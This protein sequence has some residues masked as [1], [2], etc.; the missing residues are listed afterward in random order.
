MLGNLTGK[1]ILLIIVAVIVVL[2]A[3][4]WFMDD[5]RSP[6]KKVKN[7]QN[8][9][10]TQ[11]KQMSALSQPADPT[12]GSPSENTPY[13][14]YNFYSPNCGHSVAFMPAWQQ[15]EKRIANNDTIS[16]KAIDATQPENSD[17]LFYYNIKG[18][19]TIILKT[20]QKYLEYSGD[21]T[22]EDL[23]KFIMQNVNKQ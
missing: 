15:L 18:Y 5:K 3:L 20:P 12:N 4:A 16:I 11:N 9:R 21:R 23:H 8:M 19:P 6:Q 14:L 13:T 22:V 2:Y 10:P 7:S 1:Q 17:L